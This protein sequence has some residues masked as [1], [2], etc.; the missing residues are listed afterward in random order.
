MN[1]QIAQT[2]STPESKQ[3][4][5]IAT[6][7][8]A[9]LVFISLFL[10]TFSVDAKKNEE[11][12]ILVNFGTSTIGSGDV[13]PEHDSEQANV[14]EQSQEL[15]KQVNQEVKAKTA[16]PKPSEPKTVKNE[17]LLT[18]N[19]ET[20]VVKKP[21]KKKKTTTP[22]KTSEKTSPKD[23]TG[24]DSN[25]T[26]ATEA[27]NDTKEQPK[28]NSRALYPGSKNVNSK[29]EGTDNKAGDKGQTD[30]S[31]SPGAYEGKN[32]GLGK[33][34]VGYSL[35][36]RKII[37]SPTVQ[38]NSNLE[39]KITINIKVDPKGNVIA[40]SKGRPTTIENNSL[41]QK[42]IQAAKQAKFDQKKTASEEQFGTM[43][44]VFKV[45]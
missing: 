25:T 10:I 5:S 16:A 23:D 34:G 36:G 43:T 33:S 32:S 26:K 12:G 31:P 9:I 8:T 22:K 17:E 40:A 14:P 4:A 41:L 20:A 1:N 11:E 18:Q 21:E 7:I 29:G 39:G 15:E 44:F 30:G 3:R 6:V 37:K 27:S 19:E 2:S 38:D 35:S 28:V 45:R 24:Q 42:C 13:Q